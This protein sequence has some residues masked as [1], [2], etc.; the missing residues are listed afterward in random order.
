MGK[1]RDRALMSRGICV[2]VNQP[3]QLGRRLH[4][5]HQ[6][7]GTQQ[8][9]RQDCFAQPRELSFCAYVWH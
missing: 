1:H 6:Q 8:H 7:H 3:V 4:R 5:L 2:L 9:R